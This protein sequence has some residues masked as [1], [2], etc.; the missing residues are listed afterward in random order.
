MWAKPT[1]HTYA[2][3]CAVYVLCT[4]AQWSHYHHHPVVYPGYVGAAC[5][6]RPYVPVIRHRIIHNFSAVLYSSPI[7]IHSNNSF[8]CM[9]FFFFYYIAILGETINLN[10]VQMAETDKTERLRR[11]LTRRFINFF[12]SISAKSDYLCLFSLSPSNYFQYWQS[13]M[14]T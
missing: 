6:L 7:Y 9:F 2:C 4:R 13:Y 11:R 3:I 1:T 14:T 10:T 5:F 12:I 8:G